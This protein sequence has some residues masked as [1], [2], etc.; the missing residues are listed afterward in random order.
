[1]NIKQLADFANEKSEQEFK[2]EA[3][4]NPRILFYSLLST[5]G[6]FLS[7]ESIIPAPQGKP[8]I[9]VNF[10]NF[11][12]L[13]NNCPL[14]KLKLIFDCLKNYNFAF[15]FE[16]FETVKAIISNL[17]NENRINLTTN[18]IELLI[19]NYH[20]ETIGILTES[21]NLE[22]LSDN[23]SQEQF[24]KIIEKIPL[25]RI[26][27]SPK[28]IGII[29]KNLNITYIYKLYEILPKE[30]RDI[31]ANPLSLSIVLSFLPNEIVLD[32]LGY[33]S[34]FISTSKIKSE[35]EEFV[36]CAYVLKN[37]NFRK[38]EFVINEMM[39][40][41]FQTEFP[42]GDF[43][44]IISI[45]QE[46]DN[47]KEK[48]IIEELIDLLL[49]D[50]F[51]KIEKKFGSDDFLILLHYFTREQLNRLFSKMS[52]QD[53]SKNFPMIMK[54]TKN[55]HPMRIKGIREAFKDNIKQ[56]INKI[57]QD[58][59][60]AL[61]DSQR[62]AIIKNLSTVEETISSQLKIDMEQ[63][64]ERG[65]KNSLQLL[66]LEIK[67]LA[68]FFNKKSDK[69]ITSCLYV[70]YV[71]QHLIFSSSLLLGR[72][73]RHLSKN[74]I[75]L[76]VD[77]LQIY[78]QLHE[79]NIRSSADLGMSSQ[80]LI[81][82]QLI[83][84]LSLIPAIL[85]KFSSNPT[86]VGTILN[87]VPKEY[88]VSVIIEFENSCGDLIKSSE[89]L[90]RLLNQVSNEKAEIIMSYAKAKNLQIITGEIGCIFS[91]LHII[92][93]NKVLVVFSTII[94][95]IKPFIEEISSEDSDFTFY[96]EKNKLE[97]L[98]SVVSKSKNFANII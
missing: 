10:D 5:V 30:F 81:H 69:E 84:F 57:S 63:A 51:Q 11:L 52:I 82:G 76:V 24:F 80:F 4:K 32:I 67:N 33:L 61:S 87:Y 2:T 91:L 45:L 79:K 42:F 90:A 62:I 95:E 12:Y 56:K 60:T 71:N 19:H 58:T 55:Q 20:Y 22:Y 88:V 96:I 23:L 77:E 31:L 85:K 21:E 74:K 86:H 28:D 7:E 15:P 25:T 98:L 14:E 93:T 48:I 35:N 40:S 26:I 97:K 54:E 18:F 66:N 92:E 41:P 46:L 65:N 89:F 9:S 59:S 47:T 6:Q 3:K 73:L 36:D 29:I 68:K 27:K 83:T 39:K 38:I 53:Y 94:D 16:N 72:L 50:Y 78:Y 34:K 70:L 37:F 17:N 13:I 75:K 8:E 49:K 43:F 64:P 44:T 1:M